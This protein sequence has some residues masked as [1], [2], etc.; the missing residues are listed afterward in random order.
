MQLAVGQMSRSWRVGVATVITQVSESCWQ[1]TAKP[2]QYTTPTCHTQCYTVEMM[3]M[4]AVDCQSQLRAQVALWVQYTKPMGVCQ[5]LLLHFLNWHKRVGCAL[6]IKYSPKWS[7]RGVGAPREMLGPQR[8]IQRGCWTGCWRGC[9]TKIA[10]RC[11]GSD[12]RPT[13]QRVQRLKTDLYKFFTRSPIESLL[14]T[15]DL[16]WGYLFLFLVLDCWTR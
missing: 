2:D 3:L 15:K 13:V 7:I 4:S 5:A 11:N 9:W 10:L 16:A 1:L 6:W 14:P 8:V 12:L